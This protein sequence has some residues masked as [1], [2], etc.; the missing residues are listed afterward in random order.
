MIED[1]ASN[2]AVDYSY[3]SDVMIEW[4]VQEISVVNFVASEDGSDLNL[5]LFK[6]HFCSISFQF[7]NATKKF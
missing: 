1:K 2:K 4:E 5:V 7:E 3:L 6:Y